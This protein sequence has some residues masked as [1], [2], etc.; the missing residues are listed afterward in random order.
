MSRET[1]RERAERMGRTAS[2]FLGGMPIGNA[3]CGC[4]NNL[5]GDPPALHLCFVC[6]LVAGPGVHDNCS[7]C[8]YLT[9]GR[10]GS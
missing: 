2:I 3:S 8:A 1:P 10:P 7:G 4:P 5:Y 6:G 9:E